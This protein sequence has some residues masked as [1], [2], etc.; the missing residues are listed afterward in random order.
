[1]IGVVMLT[2]DNLY[3]KPYTLYAHRPAT[4]WWASHINNTYSI[5]VCIIVISVS[6]KTLTWFCL[7]RYLLIDILGLRSNHNG[8]T[9]SNSTFKPFINIY[10]QAT[11]PNPDPSTLPPETSS[12]RSNLTWHEFDF[13]RILVA[14]AHRMFE[15][16]R[17]GDSEILLAAIDAGLPVNLTN[18]KGPLLPNN[19]LDYLHDT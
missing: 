16:A 19:R 2:N 15:A 17:N 5:C 7:A 3:K 9:K 11:A 13:A 6:D 12:Y 18:D 14:F 10:L 4:D 8:N 1:M